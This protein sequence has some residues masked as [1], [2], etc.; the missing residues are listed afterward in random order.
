MVDDAAKTALP[1]PSPVG[2]LV[3]NP[4]VGKSV[5]FNQ[6]T[7][8]Y[9]VVSNY[10]GTT[11]E[12]MTAD[13]HL[14]HGPVHTLIDTPGVN[15]LLPQS[16]DE[17]VT[18]RIILE[19]S[20][21][22]IVQVADAKNLGRT[23][24]L[25]FQLMELGIPLLLTLNMSD[26]AAR[27]GLLIDTGELTRQLNVEVVTTAAPEGEG[28]PQ[29]R[30]AIGRARMPHPPSIYSPLIQRAM[31]EIAVL[32]DRHP[33]TARLLA[34]LLLGRD[35]F[36]V[37][38][39]AKEYGPRTLSAAEAI[40]RRAEGSFP[41]PL[42]LVMAAAREKAAARLTAEVTSRP[43]ERRS[44]LAERIGVWTRRP[45]T[46]IP[47]FLLVLW[48]MYWLVGRFAAGTLVGFMEHTVFGRFVNPA[49]RALLSP[50]PWAF[51][52]D[53]FTSRFGL[54][55]MGLTYA[56]AIVLPI[57]TVFF[58]CFGFL[59]DSGYLPRLSIMS[60]RIFRHIGL[61]GKAI[62]PM[63]LG[64]GCSTMATLTSRIMETRKERLIVIILLALG[65]PCS[66]QLG[67]MLAIMSTLS[68]WATATVIGVILSQLA[69]VG[70]AAA[71]ILP[72]ETSDFILEIPP[73][74]LPRLANLGLKTY[75]R[76]EWFL[77]EAIPL[78]LLGTGILFLADRFGLLE[79]LT[80][81]AA[82]V[83]VRWLRLPADAAT[84]FVMGFFRRDY[85]AAGLFTMARQRLIDPN[86]M[87]VALV[88]ITLF[89]PCIANFLVIVKEQGLK[90]GLAIAGFI[91]PFAILVGGLLDR[92][93]NLLHIRF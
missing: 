34:L 14:P 43:A 87:V 92:A 58:L 57:V 35:S 80:R 20:P 28:V 31:G 67:V 52:R 72:G 59:E 39:L 29:L 45:L 88:V 37:E 47:V 17:T 64:L 19:R 66:A 30:K 71:R 60:N 38:W 11:V 89:V 75:L 55:T 48:I 44:T 21:S 85:G 53:L 27:Q 49:A 56:V 68:P 83:V 24:Q 79:A 42:S 25:T 40:V 46:G 50:L 6:L 91:F 1:N 76:V 61:N 10:P 36:L 63:V 16:E 41:Q 73:I 84:I 62:L 82:P 5:L 93:L 13:L 22:F 74:R 65:I 26:E 86:Q 9:A 2:L 18:Q 4:N 54:I 23:L 78:F 81:L 15:G 3:G 12:V 70:W 51:G 69:L 77:K 8:R 7:G 32:L 33:A 90:K